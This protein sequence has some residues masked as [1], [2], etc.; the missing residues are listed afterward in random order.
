VRQLWHFIYVNTVLLFI[1]YTD[2]VL[3]IFV[4]EKVVRWNSYSIYKFHHISNL[5][6]NNLYE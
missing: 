3:F 6:N 4:I 5:V 1:V 2:C